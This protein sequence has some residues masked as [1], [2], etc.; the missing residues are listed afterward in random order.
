LISNTTPHSLPFVADGIDDEGAGDG[1]GDVGDWVPSSHATISMVKP[2][3]V[4][5]AHV[6]VLVMMQPCQSFGESALR[7]KG[8]QE[9]H[10]HAMPHACLPLEKSR[11]PA[12][13]WRTVQTDPLPG[14]GMSP[15]APFSGS[16]GAGF[17]T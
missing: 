9:R 8:L 7:S 11:L 16:R 17:F 12:R 3:A 10:D 14:S 4:I 5:N 2:R 13:V 15:N 1:E 6:R